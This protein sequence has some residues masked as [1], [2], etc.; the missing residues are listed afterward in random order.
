MKIYTRH[1]DDGTTGL[2]GGVRASKAATQVCAYG[3]VDEL[4]ALLGWA[5]AAGE[6]PADVEAQLGAVQHDLFRLGAELATA[7]D[8]G[9][10]PPFMPLGSAEIEALETAIDRLEEGLSPLQHFILPGGSELGARLH[11]ARTQCRRVE[12]DVVA[13]ATSAP[14]RPEVLAYL[15]RLSDWLFVAARCCNSF[16][17][18]AEVPWQA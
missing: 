12:R 16:A 18:V 9:R 1:G 5:H 2:L 10:T 17:G 13:W 6:V 8:G 4:N 3:S 14:V 11:L 7:T 15:N